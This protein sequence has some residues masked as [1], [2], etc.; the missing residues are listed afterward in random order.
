MR[1]SARLP[2]NL[3]THTITYRIEVRGAP[4][5]MSRQALINIPP[6]HRV[7]LY[8]NSLSLEAAPYFG[9]ALR[10]TRDVV[11]AAHVYPGV[12]DCSWYG[13]MR[14]DA[15]F[16]HPD[17]VVIQYTGDRF[18]PCAKIGGSLETSVR[19]QT[20]TAISILK[21]GGTRHVYLVGKIGA[22]CPYP[23]MP[24][25]KCPDPAIPVVNRA[26]EEAAAHFNRP[27]SSLSVVVIHPEVALQTSQ[28]RYS[29]HLACTSA[30]I[31]AA[32]CVGTPF[33]RRTNWVRDI[34]GLHFCRPSWPVPIPPPG[35]RRYSSGA[36]RYGNAMALPV[37]SALGLHI[38]PGY[39]ETMKD[40]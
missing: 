10:S 15:F 24:K 22:H 2:P 4:N 6:M 32:K 39:L 34:A 28:H 1:T 29:D 13:A 18:V 11:V 14:T 8:G 35:C 25:L 3:T 37:A 31:T 36:Y 7:V 30:E 23:L 21:T 16:V 19:E 5:G 17:S 9:A 27:R 40:H 12:A 33:G 38:A 26:L 20:E